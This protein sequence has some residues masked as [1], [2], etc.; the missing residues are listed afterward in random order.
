MNSLRILAGIVGPF[1]SLIGVASVEAGTLEDIQARGS[2]IVGVP[3]D[4]PPFGMLDPSGEL[5]GYD[6][7]MARLVAE[8]L[9]VDLEVVYASGT[10]RVPFL[11]S[12]RV[13]IIISNLGKNAE[14][15]EVIDFSEPYAP[16]FNGVFGPPEIVVT[17]PEDLSGYSI[18]VGTG[19]IEDLELTAIAPPDADIRRFDGGSGTQSAYFSGA[20]D[21]IS[22][23]NVV[24]A[25]LIEMGAPRPLETKFL[26]K[27]S[28]CYIGVRE[29]DTAM[30]EYLNGVIERVKSDGTLNEISL[31]WMKA[32][33]PEVL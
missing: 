3:S 12:G 32:D 13:D 26:I 10:S 25:S 14:R 4:S 21:L 18:A 27:N 11:T 5:I 1:I 15:D 22:T 7:D 16:F 17:G 20:V 29:G 9:G 8:D 31:R 30:V 6:I 28:P 24:V 2:I 19:S 23:A 33:L